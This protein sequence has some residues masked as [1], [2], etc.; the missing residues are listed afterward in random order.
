MVFTVIPMAIVSASAE[1]AYDYYTVLDADTYTGAIGGGAAA[2][3]YQ[4]G[5]SR[6]YNV[7]ITNEANPIAAAAAEHGTNAFKIKRSGVYDVSSLNYYDSANLSTLAKDS[8]GFRAQVAAEPDNDKCV[9]TKNILSFG[10]DSVTSDGETTTH[11]MYATADWGNPYL[12]KLTT[13]GAWYTF[14]WGS[15]GM[16]VASNYVANN[17][18]SYGGG[19]STSNKIDEAFL[20]NIQGIYL[21]F[22]DPG[23]AYVGS[24]YYVDDL[25][26]I[27]P[28]G[29]A[30]ST[31]TAPVTMESGA[32]IRLG[33]VNGI[34]FYTTVDE[35]K[36]AELVGENTYEIGTIIAPADAIGEDGELTATDDC[37]IIPF[38]ARNEDGTI[39]YHNAEK[40]QIAGSIVNIRE[41][42]DETDTNGNIDR[43]FVARAYVKVGD[44][45]YYS[46][47]TSTRSLQAVAL[48]YQNDNY[49][50]VEDEAVKKYVDNW[51]AGKRK[52]A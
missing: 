47:T 4:D 43:E 31:S 2:N 23:S 51:A 34:R 49:G 33:D 30:P 44:T 39:K 22:A 37:A 5:V 3:A 20:N 41:T 10:F 13:E 19:A 29:K 11:K 40:K 7:S 9:T 38:K 46:A 27:Y 21:G 45:Y 36:L 28:E 18:L 32:S 1:E 42:G 6:A 50:G 52:D 16:N 12:G 24:V 26:F 15:K 8:V 48:A 14:M 35:T 25:Q 17:R